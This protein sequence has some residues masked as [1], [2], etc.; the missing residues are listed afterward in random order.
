MS[1]SLQMS[2]MERRAVAHQQAGEVRSAKSNLA[3]ASIPTAAGSN[4]A[5]NE[6]D[7]KPSLR[8]CRKQAQRELQAM[9]SARPSDELN[10]DLLSGLTPEELCERPEAAICDKCGA[11]SDQ[12]C[13]LD[14][15]RGSSITERSYGEMWGAWADN[16]W[17]QIGDE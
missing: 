6:R 7:W 9:T 16:I 14:E 5:R 17:E 2:A 8:A 1:T 4:C 15:P 12:G 11:R 10:T 3:T 13:R